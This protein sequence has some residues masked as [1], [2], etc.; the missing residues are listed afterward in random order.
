MLQVLTPP[1]LALVAIDKPAGRIVI[2][3]VTTAEGPCLRDELAAQLGREVWVCHRID[4]DTSGVLLFATDMK[5]HREASKAFEQGQAKKRYVALVQGLVRG[6]LDIDLPL[7]EAKSRKMRVA[8]DGEG[9]KE[10]RTLVRPRQLFK[11]ASLVE[12]EPLTGRQHQIRVHLRAK[13]HPLLVDH[14]YGRRDPLTTK[15][16]GGEGD[17]PVLARTPLHAERLEIAALGLLVEAPLPADMAQA[18]ALLARTA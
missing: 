14:Q 18:V 10:S 8:I 3:G 13:G 12:A 2:P 1:G 4:R 5:A 15:D 6:P 9:G 17:E 7:I 11:T 16:L